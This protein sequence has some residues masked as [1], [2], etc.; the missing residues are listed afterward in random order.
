M[1]KRKIKRLC[2]LSKKS[3]VLVALDDECVAQQM[4][5]AAML[6]DIR[7][8]VL[9]EVNTGMDRAGISSGKPIIGFLPK[10]W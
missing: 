1:G 3:D 2:K 7:S 8:N 4:E 5:Y 6:N 9:V 10:H